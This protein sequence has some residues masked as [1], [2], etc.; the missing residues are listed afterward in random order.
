MAPRHRAQQ[1][2]ASGERGA[3]IA[4]AR[5][6]GGGAVEISHAQRARRRHR[7]ADADVGIEAARDARA[8]RPVRHGG[9][10]AVSAA[11][12]VP[13][14]A[15]PGASA[16]VR[17]AGVVVLQRARRGRFR[18]LRRSRGPAARRTSG[19]FHPR[20]GLQYR[21][22]P[23]RSRVALE[24]PRLPWWFALD[25]PAQSPDATVLLT[26]DNQLLGA[27]PLTEPVS[28]DAVSYTRTRAL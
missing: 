6:G 1:G 22:P 10:R 4:R 14:P 12:G 13:R 2:A 17:A 16:A 11:L 25:T 26:Y 7:T 23:Y 28:F 24:P 19:A 20:Q 21:G 9:R 3:R 5:G 27:E 18:G 15:E 8:A